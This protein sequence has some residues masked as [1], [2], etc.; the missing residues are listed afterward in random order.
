MIKWTNGWHLCLS[1]LVCLFTALPPAHAGFKASPFIADSSC[2]TADYT[3]TFTSEAGHS[4]FY[5]AKKADPEPCG[6][7][8]GVL[9]TPW[10]PFQ[11]FQSISFLAKGACSSNPDVYQPAVIVEWGTSGKVTDRAFVTCSQAKHIGKVDG[12][13]E[14]LRFTAADFG[15]KSSS[16]VHNIIISDAV[17][18]AEGAFYVDDIHVNDQEVI[19]DFHDGTKFYNVTNCSPTGP[20]GSVITGLLGG[21]PG[22]TTLTLANA[23]GNSLTIFMTLGAAAP[24]TPCV[25]GGCVQDVTQVF[26]GMQ[27]AGGPLVGKIVLPAGQSV[28]YSGGLTVQGN[29]SL[30]AVLTNCPRSGFPTGMNVGEFALNVP[31]GPNP[32][33]PFQE[34]VDVSCVAGV[35]ADINVSMTDASNQPDTTWST[36]AGVVTSF[37]NGPLNANLN[38]PGV[39]PPGCDDCVDRTN[40]NP[41]ACFFSPQC[42]TQKICLPQRAQSQE[43]GTVTI[44][45]K[46]PL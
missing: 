9:I 45:F 31:I 36:G 6:T 14:R 7:Y 28:S 3:A 21:T 30:N 11:G 41:P 18:T 33:F 38:K 29:L 27:Q 34:S 10:R 39:F 46:G 22:K 40:I 26:A 2:E 32:Q 16:V 5:I 19:K 37:E 43:G 24:N 8:A 15:L 13:Y 1:L 25:P 17:T 20:L 44:T 35:N 23:S 12:G 4:A 42:N